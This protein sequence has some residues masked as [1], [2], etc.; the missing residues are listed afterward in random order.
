MKDIVAKEE[1]VEKESIDDDRKVVFA[2]DDLKVHFK[3]NE[4]FLESLRKKK[5]TEEKVVRAVDGVSFTIREGETIGLAGESGCGKTTLAKTMVKLVEATGGKIQFNGKD[6]KDIASR[7]L[8]GFRREAQMVFQDPYESL[9]P[10][11][12]VRQTL[13]EP[14]IIHGMHKKKERQERVLDT[15]EKVGLRPPEL[16]MDRYPHQMSGGQRQRVS[17][18]RGL[19]IRPSFLV[20]DEPVSMLDVSIR[21]SVLNLIKNLVKELNL[22]S[23]YISHDLSLIRYVCDKTAIMYLGRIVEM[24]STEDVIQNPIHPYS[25]ALLDAVPA[26]IPNADGLIAEL[27]G[28]A[29]NPVNIPS[30]CRFHPRCP[31]AEERCK[32]NV[33]KGVEYE[34][35]YV[36]CLL[37][38]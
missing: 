16:Y 18:A 24:G 28:E 12:S 22:A 13:E 21:A 26:P 2:I 1:I 37:F 38:E 17:I 3:V 33:P 23:V 31:V 7:D 14:L 19:I 34:G 9:N 25:K 32:H 20:A 29:P 4:S 35:R 11:F 30:G 8:K 27:E 6:L 10:R 36:E 5:G 15:L